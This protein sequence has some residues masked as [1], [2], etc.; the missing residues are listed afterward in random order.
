MHYSSQITIPP[1][2]SASQF[3]LLP[4]TLLHFLAT[5]DTIDLEGLLAMAEGFLRQEAFDR[6]S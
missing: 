5:V 4:L 1:V 6:F 3:F 2:F